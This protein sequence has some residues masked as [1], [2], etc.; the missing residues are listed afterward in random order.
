MHV[1]KNLK[2]VT[3]RWKSGGQRAKPKTPAANGDLGAKPKRSS[4]LQYGTVMI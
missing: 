4:I 2:L 3:A 1:S